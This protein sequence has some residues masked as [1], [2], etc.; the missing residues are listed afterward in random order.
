MRHLGRVV[1]GIL[2]VLVVAVVWYATAGEAVVVRHLFT[3]GTGI[4]TGTSWVP[5]DEGLYGGPV[6]AI[7]SLPQGGMP[8]Y[9]GTSEDDVFAS[10]N[11]GLTWARLNGTS[12]GHFV[13]GIELDPSEGGR[14]LGK[15]VYGAGFFLSDDGGRT[16]KNSSRGLSSRLLSCL[17]APTGASGTLFVGTGDAGLYASHDGGRSWRRIGGESL[18]SRVMAV[19]ATADGR[20]VYAGTQ[21]A[22]LSISRDGGDT[23]KAVSL[24]F[25]AE[26]I[27]TGIAIDPADERRL[28]ITVTGG[29]VGLSTDEGQSWAVSRTGS[30]SSDCSAVQFLAH[31]SS[32]LVTGTQSGALFFSQ[33]GLDWQQ[34]CQVQG[35]GD[36][37]GL[38]QSGGALL[39]ATS[40]G[41]LA[42]HDGRAWSA[43]SQGIT[44]LTLHG[45]VSSPTHASM[46][47]M[48]TD[49]GVFH[50]QDAGVSWR[51]CSEPRQILS[52]LAMQDGH[53]ILAGTSDGVVLRS[54]DGGDHWASVSRGIP[55]V[56]VNVLASPASNP[57]TVY[58]GTDNGC[59]VSTDGGLT[60]EPRNGGLVATLSA[61]SLTP[62]IEIAA[63]LPDPDSSASAILS[64]LGQGLY[65]TSDEGNHWQPLSAL[66]GTQWIVSLAAD[67]KTG[68]L[69]AG[70]SAN[71]VLVSG[72]RGATW[73]TSGTGLS[74]L[75]SVPGAINAITV[76]RDGTVYAGTQERG[77][78]LSRDG[79]V[80]W[81]LLNAGLP[82][83]AVHGIALAGD[84]V[85]AITSHHLVRLQA[86]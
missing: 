11:E 20:T 54:A 33:D 41:V 34:T 53:T 14:V 57:N 58:A 28:A 32:G 17:A 86:Q 84:S 56:K 18:G 71:G 67:Q 42:S 16:W 43:S 5:S 76:A 75:F 82:A 85:L 47:F 40:Q 72:D 60:W 6:T 39:A 31:G 24:P 37:F 52:I 65:A 83:L 21:E 9:A 19:S 55:G 80:S 81:Q 59:A 1:A 12:S 48:A 69:Y 4:A 74:S 29:G 35:N 26:P 78:A 50:S 27:V 2:T 49:Q 25:G 51:N 15:A 8:V 22:G 36:I 77:I 23:W 38:V 13:V 61:G 7:G 68:R 30:L 63:I 64:L 3:N 46:L 70:T 62:R 10:S 44:N 73:S 66:A 79:G 45:L